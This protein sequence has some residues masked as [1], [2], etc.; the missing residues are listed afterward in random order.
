MTVEPS[1]T[2][3]GEPREARKGAT[4]SWSLRVIEDPL[5]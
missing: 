4:V 2:H 3:T 1:A 5:A